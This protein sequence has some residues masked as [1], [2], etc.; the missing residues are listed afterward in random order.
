MADT[1]TKK[2]SGKE[3]EATMK[4]LLIDLVQ[5]RVF[6]YDKSHRDHFRKNKKDEAWD[7]ISKILGVPG[8]YCFIF[9]VPVPNDLKC[10][11]N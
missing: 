6:I 5:A 1:A 8:E 10:F 2:V 11:V 3:A 9:F 4:E 7:E